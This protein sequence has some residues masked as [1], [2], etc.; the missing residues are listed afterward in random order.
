[1]HGKCFWWSFKWIFC[2]K[3]FFPKIYYMYPALTEV[4]AIMPYVHFSKLSSV[5]SVA[6][7]CLQTKI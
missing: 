7:R 5:N 1:M 2:T 3:A 4:G 6:L